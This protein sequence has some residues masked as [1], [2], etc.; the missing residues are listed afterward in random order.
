VQ[1]R[2]VVGIG[3]FVRRGAGELAQS[4]REH[5]RANGVLDRLSGPQ[6]RGDRQRRDQLGGADGLLDAVAAHGARDGPSGLRQP[7]TSIRAILA[8][9]ETPDL[10]RPPAAHFGETAITGI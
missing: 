9:R 4:D 2:D 8:D 5:G 10:D 6:V 1:Q 7:P 3:E